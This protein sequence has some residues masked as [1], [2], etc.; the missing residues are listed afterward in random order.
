MPGAEL[1]G[2][3][4]GAVERSLCGWGGVRRARCSVVRP[5]RERDVADAVVA[6]VASAG[7]T[8]ARGAGRSYG[9]AAQLAG[10]LVL[11]MTGLTRV[12]EVDAARGLVR[13][14]AGARL[15]T[16]LARLGQEGM[17]LP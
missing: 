15:A 17:T 10:G 5:L 8:I 13:A 7:G 12:V 16:L 14:Q 9:D 3:P 6:A 4:V 2:A 11:D 1:A